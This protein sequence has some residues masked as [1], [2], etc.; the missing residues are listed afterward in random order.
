M[1]VLFLDIDGVMNSLESAK[2]Y[3]SYQ[4]LMPT[5]L[6]VL[7][8]LVHTC[9]VTIVVSSTWRKYHTH[10]ELSD[11]L[12]VPINFTTPIYNVDNFNRGCEIKGW[13]ATCKEVE[14]YCIIDDG[15]FDILPEQWPFFV[16]TNFEVGARLRDFNEICRILQV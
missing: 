6:T 11:A 3:G 15:S 13:L 2:E 7:H 5:A 12:N 14:R 16:H 1:K 4:K 8:R 9:G 10:K